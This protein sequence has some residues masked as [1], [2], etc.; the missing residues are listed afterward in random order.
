MERI[1]KL[2]LA[3]IVLLVAFVASIM[4]GVGTAQDPADGIVMTAETEDGEITITGDVSPGETVTI[5]LTGELTDAKVTVNDEPVTLTDADGEIQVTV[6]DNGELTIVIESE[7]ADHEIYL[8]GSETGTEVRSSI[9]SSTSS[10]TSSGSSTTSTKSST[11]VSTSTS[12][13][14]SSDST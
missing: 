14:T 3:K 4:I 10:T 2:R 1:L 7:Q 6:P 12:T 5:T 11:T 13:S 8:A 9:S